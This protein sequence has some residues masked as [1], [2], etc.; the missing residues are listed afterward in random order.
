MAK[1][2]QLPFRLSEDTVGALRGWLAELNAQQGRRELL[3]EAAL[4]RGVLDWASRNRPLCAFE[5]R[6]GKNVRQ[7]S[8]RLAEVTV[9]DLTR[10]L[11][12]LNAGR[13]TPLTLSELARA[14]LDWACAS[15]PDWEKSV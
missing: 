10:W 1:D 3:K 6:A 4:V 8:I 5:P 7:T 2:R 12:V 15:R 13:L 9:E 14:V 11:G